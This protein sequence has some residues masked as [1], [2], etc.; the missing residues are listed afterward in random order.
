MKRINMNEQ[1]LLF[2]EDKIDKIKRDLERSRA[3]YEMLR[4]SMHARIGAQSKQK[5]G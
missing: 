1:L 4:K 2:E 3:S 5:S